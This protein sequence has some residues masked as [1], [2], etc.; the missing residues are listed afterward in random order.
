M[1]AIIHELDMILVAHALVFAG[2]KL[3][4]ALFLCGFIFPKNNQS[5][6]DD[7]KHNNKDKSNEAINQKDQK[8]NEEIGP[9]KEDHNIKDI[10]EQEEEK[11]KSEEEFVIKYNPINE[12]NYIFVNVVTVVFVIM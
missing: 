12:D 8:I 5:R 1:A 11:I 6:D 3:E 9:E 4:G 2:Y 7:E 10:E